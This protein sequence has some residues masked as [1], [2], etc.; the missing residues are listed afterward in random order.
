[1]KNLLLAFAFILPVSAFA[2]CK[3]STPID[4][5]EL[6]FEHKSELF[7]RANSAPELKVI[8]PQGWE[9]F[10]GAPTYLKLTYVEYAPEH[11][12][13]GSGELLA[14]G[15]N[16]SF[17]DELWGIG[18]ADIYGEG[19]R[20]EKSVEKKQGA[21]VHTVKAFAKRYENPP[22]DQM[23]EY[24]DT[25]SEVKIVANKIVSINIS[26]TVYKGETKTACVTEA[27]R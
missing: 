15:A 13:F 4:M 18:H 9:Y 27:A 5:R 17:A 6:K 2:A 21:I 22:S 8:D 10:P 14:I 11:I 7:T 23:E 3:L 24:L 16:L 12:S 25:M 20:L 1:M 19:F 26:E